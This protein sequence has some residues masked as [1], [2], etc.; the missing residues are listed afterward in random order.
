MERL[1]VRMMLNLFVLPALFSFAVGAEAG[2]GATF[3]EFTVDLAENEI[4]GAGG[5]ERG[6]VV[7]GHFVLGGRSDGLDLLSEEVT[8]LVGR[9]CPFPVESR[10][11]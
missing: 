7:A 10:G 5:R 4:E 1:A 6:F 9:A 3:S 8:I 11:L 2:H